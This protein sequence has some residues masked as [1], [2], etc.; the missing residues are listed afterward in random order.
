MPIIGTAQIT[1]L[2][3]S[4]GR[5]SLLDLTGSLDIVYD[6]VGSEDGWIQ[7]TEMASTPANPS[8]NAGKI[9]VADDSSSTKLYFRDSAGTQ[10]ELGGSGGSATNYTVSSQLKFTA[11]SVSSRMYFADDPDTAGNQYMMTGVYIS[12]PSA[13]TTGA[14]DYSAKMTS[15]EKGGPFWLAPRNCK[16][17]RGRVRAKGTAHSGVYA[18]RFEIF[19]GTPPNDFAEGDDVSFTPIGHVD[20]SVDGTM[21]TDFTNGYVYSGSHDNMTG[22]LS[23]GDAVVVG[24]RAIGDA[25]FTYTTSYGTL[26]LEFQST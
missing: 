13:L 23:K 17:I 19:K 3:G 16:L 26:T 11:A 24:F 21:A 25:S 15:G 22:T 1:N 12:Y 4:S 14:F 7:L 8:A 20:I 18:G 6:G 5:N 2:S 9:Y 10:T